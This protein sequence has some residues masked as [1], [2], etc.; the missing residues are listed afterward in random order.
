MDSHLVSG[1]FLLDLSEL[2]AE[3]GDGVTSPVE[4]MI[5]V[6]Y[7]GVMAGYHCVMCGGDF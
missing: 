1:S 7:G 2:F 4:G 5:M 3:G 6:G